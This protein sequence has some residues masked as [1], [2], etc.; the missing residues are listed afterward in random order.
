MGWFGRAACVGG[1]LLAALIGE[2]V[3]AAPALWVARDADTEIYLFGTMHVLT[4]KARWRTRAYDAAY[5]K[6]DT[7]W[8]EADLDPIDPPAIRDLIAR[9]GVDAER[10]LSRK[11]KPAELAALK[12]ILAQGRMPLDHIDQLRPWAAALVLSIQPMTARGYEVESGAD[13]TVTRQARAE[14]KQIRTFET[15][16]DQVRMF[17]ALPEPAELQYLSDVIRD[18]SGHPRGGRGGGSL[19]DA[20]IAGDLARLGPGLVGEMQDQSPAFYE[21]FLLRRNLAWA[22][23]L[24]KEMAQ[25]G[26]SH[27][28]NVGALHMV[29]QHGLPALLEARGFKVQRIQ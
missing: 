23:V 16:E 21:A 1:V 20:W 4:P 2:P 29:G 27:L 28:V 22:D 6:A 17:A 3:A 25:A 14:V 24:E 11:L 15:L 7:V 19:E 18:R 12:P 13:L 9:Y 26:G 8:F 10:P 5:A